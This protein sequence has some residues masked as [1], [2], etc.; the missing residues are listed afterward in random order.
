MIVSFEELKGT[1]FNHMNDEPKPF[2]TL[3]FRLR[4]VKVLFSCLFDGL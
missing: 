3:I 2:Q 4:N 1:K